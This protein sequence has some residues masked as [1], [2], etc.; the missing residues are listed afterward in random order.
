MS[1]LSEHYAASPALRVL[2][3]FATPLPRLSPT[4]SPEDQGE[5]YDVVIVGA[6]PA[7]LM[8]ELLLARYGLGDDALLCVDERESTL[9]MGHA[10]G[11][12]P[13]TLETM[14]SLGL[15]DEV[16]NQGGQL[17]SYFLS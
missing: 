14:K 3:S 15:V 12:Q 11:L 6:G 2:P 5:K 1:V 4:I 13:R 17:W 16:L 9:K 10:D 7:G 8:L